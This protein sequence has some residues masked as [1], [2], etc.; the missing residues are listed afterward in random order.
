MKTN[1]LRQVTYPYKRQI[2]AVTIATHRKKQGKGLFFAQ[3]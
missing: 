2:L 1:G 3:L